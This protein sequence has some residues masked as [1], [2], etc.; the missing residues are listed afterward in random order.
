MIFEVACFRRY[1]YNLFIEVENFLCV[2]AKKIPNNKK[3]SVI[4][5]Q[6]FQ[7]A[8]SDVFI[9]QNKFSVILIED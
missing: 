5:S 1:D 9:I 3:F 4:H 8:A 7:P 2:S 6:N